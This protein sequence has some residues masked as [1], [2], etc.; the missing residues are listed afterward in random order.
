MSSE[1][2]CFIVIKFG[3][4]PFIRLC[5]EHLIGSAA[6]TRFTLVFCR[7][8]LSRCVVVTNKTRFGLDL[9]ITPCTVTSDDSKLQ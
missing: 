3:M 5:N 6:Y 8:I 7:D 1:D 2:K 4:V 9:L